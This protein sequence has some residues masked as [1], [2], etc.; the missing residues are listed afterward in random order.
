MI[1]A[2]AGPLNFL[3]RIE[4]VE[5]LPHMFF[6]LFLPHEVRLELS[7]I[8][9][10][11]VVTEWV[12]APPEWVVLGRPVSHMVAI[13]SLHSGELSAMHHAGQMRGS[14]LLIDDRRAK[15][16]ALRRGIRTIGTLAALY[17]AGTSG[18]LDFEQVLDKLT[19]LDFRVSKGLREDFIERLGAAR[20]VK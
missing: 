17:R 12:T 14:W 10:P 16:E 18:M 7:H 20:P 9:T 8:M 2:D 13:G 15:N 4:Q 1:V 19:G 11:R 3:I 6:K 5:I